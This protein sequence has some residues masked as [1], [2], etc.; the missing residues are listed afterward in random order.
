MR[1]NNLKLFDRA[2][3]C[4][5]STAI[6][7]SGRNFSYR[8]LLAASGRVAGSLLDGGKDLKGERIAFMVPPGLAFA[9]VSPRA[10]EAS[11]SSKTPRFYLD[12]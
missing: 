5:T 4:K 2:E 1:G 11:K 3:E 10:I 6:I 7:V 12:F 9:S 8:D